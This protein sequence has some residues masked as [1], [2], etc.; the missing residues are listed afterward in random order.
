MRKG[1][2]GSAARIIELIDHI[3]SDLSLL[4]KTLLRGKHLTETERKPFR[5]VRDSE[6]CGLWKNRKD[7]QGLSTSE[8]L[9][10]LRKE[11]WGKIDRPRPLNKALA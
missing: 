11:Q 9:A 3:E 4:R 6:F 8:W 2:N 1:R 7:M 5:S 10:N